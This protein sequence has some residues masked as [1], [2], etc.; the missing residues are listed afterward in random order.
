MFGD[1]LLEKENR[2]V[3]LGNTAGKPNLP[4]KRRNDAMTV[5]V[6]KEEGSC[7]KFLF[8]SQRSVKLGFC[9]DTST[10]LKE[11]KEPALI[12][13]IEP[14]YFATVLQ[15]FDNPEIEVHYK[16]LFLFR[17]VVYKHKNLVILNKLDAIIRSKLKVDT[18]CDIF[19]EY[20]RL[21]DLKQ[22]CLCLK[23]LPLLDGDH[24]QILC[25]DSFLRMKL[26]PGLR[27][28]INS[29]CLRV[30]PTA[31]WVKCQHWVKCQAM[32]TEKV[33]CAAVLIQLGICLDV[34][35]KRMTIPHFLFPI[36]ECRSLEE[37]NRQCSQPDGV[38]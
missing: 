1:P 19:V 34:F 4:S 20:S 15:Y 14:S 2:I 23:A 33:S 24:H 27:N 7:Q 25:S 28:L 18:F 36:Q 6:Q 8:S 13:K 5:L 21:N 22:I 9:S 17:K 37:K 35:S 16:H 32:L 26:D 31:L 11:L 30:D 12:E 10:H 38:L 3:L 29:K